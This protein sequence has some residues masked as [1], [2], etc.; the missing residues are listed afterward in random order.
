MERQWWTDIGYGKTGLISGTERKD[1]GGLIWKDN[2][3][4]IGYGK[5]V[6]D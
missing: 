1:S 2:G 5:T 3:G 6:V 4:D